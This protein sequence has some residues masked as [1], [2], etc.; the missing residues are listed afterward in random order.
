MNSH[1][2]SSLTGPRGQKGHTA[3]C[4]QSSEAEQRLTHKRQMSTSAFFLKA[5]PSDR[6]LSGWL[7][8][9]H[10]TLLSP[11]S[12][13]LRESR[14][15]PVFHSFMYSPF[16]QKLV[17]YMGMRV[18]WHSCWTNFFFKM[19]FF[20]LRKTGP[21]LTSVPILLYFICGTAVT[22]WLA[23][24]CHVRTRDPKQ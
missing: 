5:C 19:V 7:I 16:H 10:P 14:E 22:A 15:P 2:R 6:P 18:T 23:K 8:W 24:R 12:S 9:A 13:P 1:Q 17:E 21:E 20:F 4:A 3:S 11:C